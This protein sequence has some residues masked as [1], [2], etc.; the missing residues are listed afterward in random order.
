MYLDTSVIPHTLA[1]D[2]RLKVNGTTAKYVKV[3]QGSVLETGEVISRQYDQQGELLGENIPLELV[4]TEEGDNLAIKT[5]KVGHCSKSLPDG[6]VVTAVFYD[7]VGNVTSINSLLVKNTGWIR[8][9]NASV[10]YV[11]G[12]EL[13][14]PFLSQADNRVLECPINVPVQAITRRGIVHYSDGTK[15]TL[16]IDGTKFHL[17]GLQRFV[18]TVLG[19]RQPLSLIYYLSPDEVAY[20]SVPGDTMH[21]TEDYL[22]T[23]VKVDGAYS[24]KLYSYPVWVDALNG[25]R[26]EHFLY[27]L[28]RDEVYEV[29][30]LVEVAA[31]SPAYD[32][33]AYGVSQDITF[34]IDLSRVADR[35]KNY[36][37]LQTTRITLLRP[38]LDNAVNWTVTYEKTKPEY[39]VT[40]E[41]N[42]LRADVEFINSNLWH[43][44]IDNDMGSQEHW[45]REIYEKTYPLYDATAEDKPPVPNF[46]RLIAGSYELECS[47]GMWNHEFT[48][49][50]LLD[51]GENVYLQFFRRTSTTDLHLSTAA[52]IMRQIN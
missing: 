33:L 15:K 34:A 20:D 38:G 42:A 23:T 37:H 9:L 21:M 19:Q 35:F 18:S 6:E 17:F 10:K 22:A 1:F 52:L 29:T 30:S 41:G 16:P 45:L 48:I 25:Y 44:K 43:L 47:I 46:F 32:P 28:E 24:V 7:D 3:F 51:S 49:N 40:E 31:N 2:S 27:N 26:L 14:S 39:G 4:L 11:T 12:I 50:N 5:P 8:T 36:R 13:E